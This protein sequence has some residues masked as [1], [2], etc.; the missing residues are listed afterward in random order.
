MEYYVK[1]GIIMQVQYSNLSQE[2]LNWQYS[3]SLSAPD[4]QEIINQW[5]SDSKKISTDY[6]QVMHRNIEYGTHERQIFDYFLPQKPNGKIVIFIHGGFWQILSKEYALFPAPIYLEH[7]FGY[8]AINYRLCPEVKLSDII[9]D[10]ATCLARFHHLGYQDK[11]IILVGHSAGAYLA[12][13]FSAYHHVLIGG[14]FDLLPVQ[15]CSRNE[16]IM[17]T[18]QDAAELTLTKAPKSHHIDII[19]GGDET[20]QFIAQ[21]EYYQAVCGEK[22]AKLHIIPQRHHFNLLNDFA[23]GAIADLIISKDKNN[24]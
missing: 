15:A 20:S 1:K 13:N 16:K 9:A 11:D 7:G 14:V 12:A 10:I 18:R 6:A 3:P 21:S 2:E 4:W 24:V 19:V 22:H 17:L 8:G 23:H 5:Q